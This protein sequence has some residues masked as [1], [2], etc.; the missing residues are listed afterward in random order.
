MEHYTRCSPL[1]AHFHVL[2]SSLHLSMTDC[3]NTM[4]ESI[5]VLALHVSGSHGMNGKARSPQK[6]HSSLPQQ[7]DT[8]EVTTEGLPPGVLNGLHPVVV[9]SLACVRP[10]QLNSS[11][12]AADMDGRNFS[13]NEFISSARLPITV[14]VNK[15]NVTH[16]SAASRYLSMGNSNTWLINSS[17]H[18]AASNAAAYRSGGPY[19][20]LVVGNSVPG[21]STS[22]SYQHQNKSGTLQMVLVPVFANDAAMQEFGLQSAEQYSKVGGAQNQ[23]D[24]FAVNVF[25]SIF[26]ASIHTISCLS[27]ISSSNS[28]MQSSAPPGNHS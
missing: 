7:Q 4:P 14:D 20:P 1:Q 21:L 17:G 6:R 2:M 9:L 26:L 3:T 11:F 28:L 22:I 27:F 15:P 25:G 16:D 19:S 18:L 8:V 23:Q 10:G 5:S 24:G 13:S 12:N